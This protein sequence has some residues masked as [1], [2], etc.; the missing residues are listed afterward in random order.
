M[1]ELTIAKSLNKAYRQVPVERPVFNIF[2][3]QLSNYYKQISSIDTEEKL[4]GD[5]MDFLKFTFYS[6]NYKVS[7]NGDIDC[8]IHL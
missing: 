6:Q 2:K 3:A 1:A 8:A 4:K 7:P 5:L